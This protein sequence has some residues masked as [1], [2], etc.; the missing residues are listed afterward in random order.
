LS[1]IRVI[2]KVEYRVRRLSQS[3]RRMPVV[4]MRVFEKTGVC[5]E[6]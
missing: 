4:L 6:L 1:G 2:L 3:A 5:M